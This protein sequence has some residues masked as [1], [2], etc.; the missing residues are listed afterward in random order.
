MI[1]G[2]IQAVDEDDIDQRFL[3]PRWVVDLSQAVAGDIDVGRCGC[4]NNDQFRVREREEELTMA[5]SAAT[6]NVYLAFLTS[7]WLTKGW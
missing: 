2:A 4:L 1:G 3:G 5:V 7:C 6:S